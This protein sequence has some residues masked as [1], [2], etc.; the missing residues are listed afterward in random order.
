MFL[1][2]NKSIG[3]QHVQ[4][5]RKQYNSVKRSIYQLVLCIL[6]YLNLCSEPRKLTEKIYIIVILSLVPLVR[7][8]T[9]LIIGTIEK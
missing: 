9:R 3:S 5:K 6:F 7:K 2:T 4:T 8:F 1:Y